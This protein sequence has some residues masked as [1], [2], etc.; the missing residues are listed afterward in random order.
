MGALLLGA[1]LL[2]KLQLDAPLRGSVLPA[3][4]ASVPPASKL[5]A[6]S[7]A[8]CPTLVAASSPLFVGVSATL[9]L[10]V[11]LWNA[12]VHPA[13]ALVGEDLP[14][15]LP[16]LQFSARPFVAPVALTIARL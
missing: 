4:V 1:A 11:A 8:A 2:A 15:E 7:M 16:I 14:F 5:G 3:A 13:S 9:G 12:A 10:P 6:P